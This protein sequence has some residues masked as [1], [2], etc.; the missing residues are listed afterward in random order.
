M[1]AQARRLPRRVRAGRDRDPRA[2]WHLSRNDRVRPAVHPRELQ[3]IAAVPVRTSRSADHR[4]ENLQVV[5]HMC[6]S[7]EFASLADRTNPAEHW[8]RVLAARA[9]AECGGSGVGAIGMCFTGGFVLAMG[10]GSSRAGS[11][12]QPA[13]PA[14]TGHGSTAA[15][16][17]AGPSPAVLVVGFRLRGVR[18]QLAHALFRCESLFNTPLFVGFQDSSPSCR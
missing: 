1:R 2:S 5:V 16:A 12:R 11:G 8:L 9:H 13:R 10:G 18:G 14:G 4:A 17:R 7:R 15:R 3:G 6:A